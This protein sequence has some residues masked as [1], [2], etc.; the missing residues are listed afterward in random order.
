MNTTDVVRGL[1]SI[2][3]AFKHPMLN[4]GESIASVHFGPIKVSEDGKTIEALFSEE[5]TSRIYQTVIS[6]CNDFMKFEERP[7]PMDIFYKCMV[8]EDGLPVWNIFKSNV[9]VIKIVF[10]TMPVANNG[11]YMV[12]ISSDIQYHGELKSITMT[13]GEP[14]PMVSMGIL[15]PKINPSVVDNCDIGSWSSRIYC[16]SMILLNSDIDKLHKLLKIFV[17]GKL[18]GRDMECDY[19]LLM[20]L[21]GTDYKVGKKFNTQGAL[22]VPYVEIY[23]QGNSSAQP[24]FIFCPY[25]T[26]TSFSGHEFSITYADEMDDL[27][28]WVNAYTKTNKMITVG[29]Y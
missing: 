24:I 10:N 1:N 28:K 11:D 19:N 21:I 8:D 22:S 3:G 4:S 29:K 18:I 26:V 16:G 5:E 12:D 9:N 20:S 23:V 14:I 7:K 6:V 15:N 25:P 13:N 27:R 17:D 2:I